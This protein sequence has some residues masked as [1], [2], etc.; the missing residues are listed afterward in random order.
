M[1]RRPGGSQKNTCDGR[2]WDI[3]GSSDGMSSSQPRE[4][5]P[6]RQ[7]L[8]GTNY[9][10]HHDELPARLVSRGTHSPELADAP[11]HAKWKQDSALASHNGYPEAPSSLWTQVAR[12]VV[13]AGCMALRER[14]VPPCAAAG[15][16]P[17]PRDALKQAIRQAASCVGDISVCRPAFRD[18]ALPLTSLKLAKAFL[19]H[20]Q[21]SD[22]LPCP[23]ARRLQGLSVAGSSDLACFT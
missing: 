5:G 2:E 15:G 13:R 16:R 11:Q 9:P 17:G 3:G 8:K 19:P 21:S 22:P 18:G 4:A 1:M 10:G 12:V 20:P 14:N 23:A 7:T 6:A